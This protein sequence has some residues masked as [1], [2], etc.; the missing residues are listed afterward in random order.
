MKEENMMEWLF[1]I[2]PK[3]GLKMELSFLFFIVMHLESR[4]DS[5]F[6]PRTPDMR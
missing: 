5:E 1:K 2:V 3:F 4:A 6:V